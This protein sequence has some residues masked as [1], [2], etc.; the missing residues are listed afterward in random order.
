MSQALQNIPAFIDPEVWIHISEAAARLAMHEASLRRTC[1][2][3]A[4]REPADARQMTPAGGGKATWFV[5]R[6]YHPDLHVSQAH[7]ALHQEPVD[8]L[9]MATQ[10]RRVGALNRADCVKQLRDWRAREKRPVK[11]WLEELLHSLARQYPDLEPSRSR[12]YAWEK[13]L[14]FPEDVTKLIDG[15]GGDCT[16]PPDAAAVDHFRK[17]YLG[18]QQTKAE[19]WRATRDEA[20]EQGWRWTSYSNLLNYFGKFVTEDD[21]AKHRTPTMHRNRFAPYMQIDPESQEV[22][23]VWLGDHS[24]MDFWVRFKGQIIRPWVTVWIDWRSRRICGWV[25]SDS[26]NGS[27]IMSS[28][29]AGL[30]DPVNRGGPAIVYIDNGKDYDSW[31]LQGETK[32]QRRNRMRGVE[33]VLPHHEQPIQGLKGI[34]PGDKG[35]FGLMSVECA[36]TNPYA[37]RSKGRCERWFGTMHSQFCKSWPSYCGRSPE[38]KPDDVD[39]WMQEKGNLVPT[40]EEARTAFAL[41]VQGYNASTEHNKEDMAGMSPDQMYAERCTIERRLV[42]PVILDMLLQKWMKTVTVNRNGITIY[43]FGRQMVYGQRDRWLD[44]YKA[45]KLKDRPELRVSYDPD[46]MEHLRVWTI[47]WKFLGT[48]EWNGW[49]TFAPGQHLQETTMRDVVKEE[50]RA[51]K[52]EKAARAARNLRYDTAAQRAA[53]AQHAADNPPPAPTAPGTIRLV[54]TPVDGAVPAFKRELVKKAVGAELLGLDGPATATPLDQLKPRA[55]YQGD[56]QPQPKDDIFG[57]LGGDEPRGSWAA[58]S[59]RLDQEGEA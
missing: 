27:T 48:I 45:L 59:D 8:A 44:Q 23:V 42:D 15:R 7:V 31:F 52:T 53:K 19:C 9:M 21:E 5:R 3:L 57:D 41:F 4:E 54:Q 36:H 1:Q 11:I 16:V 17:R 39:Q 20:D 30:V 34:T 49:A 24:Q 13:A 35:L 38:N 58:L 56:Q 33:T 12:I 28:F 2:A 29:R 22:G 10:K 40:F 14:K 37:A 51:A 25:M 26:P 50:R 47:D 46:A 32:R 43:P 18:T 6:T 55:A